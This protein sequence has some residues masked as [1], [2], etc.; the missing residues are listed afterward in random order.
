MCICILADNSRVILNKGGYI[1]ACF[2]NVRPST[3][4]IFYTN[5]TTYL[6][7][8]IKGYRHSKAFIV[9]PGPMKSTVGDFWQMIWE[10]KCYTIVM[11]GQLQEN[12]KVNINMKFVLTH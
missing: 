10:N 4:T 1:N 2:V 9:G 8:F 5:A 11:L 6:S 3:F 12:K 7:S